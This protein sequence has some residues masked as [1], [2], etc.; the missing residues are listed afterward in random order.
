MAPAQFA[1]QCVAFLPIRVSE[2]ELA[3]ITEVGI[4]K[5]FAEFFGQGTG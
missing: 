5:T 1:T 4:G 2:V 3:E